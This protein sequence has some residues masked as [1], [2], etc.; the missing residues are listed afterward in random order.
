LPK[1]SN[2]EIET[3]GFDQAYSV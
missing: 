2:S 1:H 3:R